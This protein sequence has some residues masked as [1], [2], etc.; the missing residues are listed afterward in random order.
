MHDWLS[1]TTSKSEIVEVERVTLFDYSV[2][3]IYAAM[4]YLL[5]LVVDQYALLA[6]CGLHI[7]LRTT[8]KMNVTT[9]VI[10]IYL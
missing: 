7:W 1:R 9:V 2:S 10:E 3:I 8:A 6:Y 5:V 4:P